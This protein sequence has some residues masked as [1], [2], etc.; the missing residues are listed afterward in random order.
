MILVVALLVVG[1]D[2]LPKVARKVGLFL[3]ELRRQGEDVKTQVRDMIDDAVSE[4]DMS[5]TVDS[6][7]KVR[8]S[9]SL[10]PQRSTPAPVPPVVVVPGE[11]LPPATNAERNSTDLQR[12]AG[13][14][15]RESTD[16]PS[17]DSKSAP[18][19]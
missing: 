10:A 11:D 2:E 14:S 17:P 7:N 12:D 3:G 1:P 5:S 4:E 18:E 8:S 9:L 16:S 13:E 15:S 6:I 19:S